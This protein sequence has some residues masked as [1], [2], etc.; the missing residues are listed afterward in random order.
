M[1]IVID[2]SLPVCELNG[3]LANA[4]LTLKYVRKGVSLITDSCPLTHDEK[5]KALRHTG[6]RVI[7]GGL[8]QSIK[9][10]LT[11]NSA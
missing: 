8:E 1:I 7:E 4:G 6:L 5:V 2:D 3:R 11:D 10:M 9:T